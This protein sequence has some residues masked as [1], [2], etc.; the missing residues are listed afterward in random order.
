[1][2]CLL[3]FRRM[4]LVTLGLLALVGT[5]RPAL[6]A[7]ID[8]AKIHWTSAG[9]GLAV[10]FVHGWTCDET[11]WQGQVPEF[12]KQ[13]RVITLD[14]PGHGKSD[15]PKDGKFSMELFARAVE[16]VRVEAKIDRAVFVGH[17]MGTPVI[18]TYALMY[19][20]HVAGLV[21]VDGL[22][23]VAGA[24]SPFTP[25]PMLGKE[26]MQ[27]REKMVRGMFGPATTPQLQQHILKMMLGTKEATAAG[28]MNATWD[29]S[30]VKNDPITVPVL[31]IYA[32]T[33]LAGRDAITRIFPKVEYH[34][35]PGSAHF[36][37]MEKP[38][39]FNPLLSAFL[40]KLYR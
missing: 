32:G 4:H 8:G 10:I 22:V 37:M 24:A 15:L 17:S 26:G 18:R 19:P 13:Y 40:R 9:S 38:D 39:E 5:A 14:L 29:Q 12:S 21:L 16:A 33:P 36:L 34:E 25:P 1:M 11:S 28:A 30:W 3:T 31:G 35:I 6:A 20:A 27:A 7:D 23:Q 2:N